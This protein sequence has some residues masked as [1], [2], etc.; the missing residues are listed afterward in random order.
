M[1]YF[2][3]AI[4]NPPYKKINSQSEHRAGLRS[5]GIETVNLYSA[6][7]M[8][9]I[10]LLADDGELVA[11]IP[12]SFCN[13]SYYKPFREFL[14]RNTS[15][16]RIHL[17]E[18]RNSAFKEDDVLQENVI[19]HLMKKEVQGPVILSFSH[20]DSFSDLSSYECS[21]DEILNKGDQERF[22]RIPAQSSVGKR[23]ECSS[24]IRFSLP[25][26]EIEVS[27]GPI[28]DFRLR[29]FLCDQ[30]ELGSVPLLY[31]SHFVNNSIVWPA[32][33]SKK[34]NAIKMT[35]ETDKWL[36]PNGFYVVVRRLSSKEEKH[37]IVASLVDPSRLNYQKVGFENHLNVFHR[38]KGG[39]DEDLARGLACFLNSSFVDDLFR[40]FNGHTQVNATDLRA[41]KY[42]SREVLISLGRW[43][44]ENLM[45]TDESIDQKI[46]EIY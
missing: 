11:I 28:V 19:I 33:D 14:L 23:L 38:T 42:P 46:K 4:L 45:L 41:L 9:S 29:E 27:T 25:E 12:R 32:E 15:I 43:A 26:I 1:S 16:K 5:V 39:L 3:H 13:G 37:R 17:F 2:T 22:I 6:F 24:S 10:M 31:P 36:W 18:S 21:F 40:S 44:K 7:V 34:P 20:D 30:P 35:L 8:L